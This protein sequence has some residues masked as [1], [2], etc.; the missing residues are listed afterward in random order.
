MTGNFRLEL[1]EL[2]ELLNL[3]VEKYGYDFTLYSRASLYRRIMSAAV[4]GKFSDFTSLK[5]RLATD[6]P[7]FYNFVEEVTVNV[8][9]M[10]RDPQ[11]YKTLREK[12]IPILATYPLIRI[13][14]AGCSTGEEV[15]SMAIL[16]KEAGLLHKSILYATDLNQ[17]VI[18][19]ARSGI[20]NIGTMQRNSENYITS[21]GKADFSTYYRAN[22]NLVKFDESLS[23]RMVFSMHNLVSD[24]SFN[25]FQLI[26]CR[27]VLIYF[28]KP[29]QS[30][31]LELFD[32]SMDTL[33]F[34]AL[35]SKESLKFSTI[36]HLYSAVDVKEKIW[37]RKK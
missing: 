36:A 4:R 30:K 31:V 37:R 1:E 33:G 27:N 6:P 35:G 22:Y 7:Y 25:E 13:W 9:E 14:H 8:T 15:Y 18:E 3:L 10:F 17:S 20:F 24:A 29:L 26:M 19:S 11:F 16:L 23:A 12:I 2:E 28:E 32:K 34:L 5:L 21:G